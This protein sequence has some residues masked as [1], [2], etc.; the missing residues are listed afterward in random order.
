MTRLY[1]SILLLFTLTVNATVQEVDILIWKGETLTLFSNPLEL[2]SDW[3]EISKIINIELEN[4]NKRLY[5]EKYKSEED[6]VMF[7]TGCGR[8]YIV[9]W[10]IINDKIYLNNIYACR[11]PKVKVNLKKIFAK[12]LK[13]NLLFANWI[14]DKLNVPK[15]ECIEYEPL[16]YNSIYETETVLDFN[17]GVLVAFKTYNNHI[18]KKSKFSVDPNP[19]NYSDFIYTQVDWKKIPDLKNNHIQVFIAIQPNKDGKIDSILSDYTY[20]LDSNNGVVITD[21]NNVFIKEAIRIAELVP[22][23]SVIYQRGLIVSRGFSI[24]FN[25]NNRK[26]YAR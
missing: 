20:M 15:G 6:E 23:W 4:E 7:S 17:R 5:P 24:V 2:R 26:K 1:L 11:N 19:N 12:E 13:N 22:D 18:E 8:G 9:E 3:K 16:A 10:V 14:T 25:E 21:R